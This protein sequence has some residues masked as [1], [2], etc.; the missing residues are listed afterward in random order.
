[1]LLYVKGGGV[2]VTDGTEVVVN[3]TTME[4]R[5]VVNVEVGT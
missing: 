1:M 2:T 3:W 4:L 5:V